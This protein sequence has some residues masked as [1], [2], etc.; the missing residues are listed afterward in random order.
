MSIIYEKLYYSF[1]A[2]MVKSEGESDITHISAILLMSIFQIGFCLLIELILEYLSGDKYIL[3][4]LPATRVFGLSTAFSMMCVNILYFIKNP[5]QDIV[6]R[7]KALPYKRSAI[8]FDGFIILTI[9]LAIFYV[10]LNN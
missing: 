1:Y 9:M 3:F 2:V 7:E 6:N 4:G 10:A 5:Y 8:Y